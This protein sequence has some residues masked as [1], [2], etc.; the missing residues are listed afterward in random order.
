MTRTLVSL[1]LACLA[2]AH[3]AADCTAPESPKLPPGASSTLADMLEGQK[4]VKAFQA[5]NMAYMKCLEEQFTAA[6][7]ASKKGSDEEKAAAAEE[8]QQ[9]V[10]AYNA[11]VSEEEAV[12]GQFNTEIR[13]YKE[14]NP[15]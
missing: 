10:N 12:A 6:E 8:Y 11:A 3:A 15:D 1:L 14:A 5:D 2:A 9:A 4:A 13:A 7:K